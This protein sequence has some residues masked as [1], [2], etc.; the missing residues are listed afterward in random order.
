MRRTLLTCACTILFAIPL[1]G[2]SISFSATSSFSATARSAV[3]GFQCSNLNQPVSAYCMS[4]S[5]GG[6]IFSREYWSGTVTASAGQGAGSFIGSPYLVQALIDVTA[7]CNSPAAC[8]SQYG[9]ADVG[10]DLT[11]HGPQGTTGI[12]EVAYIFAY[13]PY[14]NATYNIGLPLMGGTSN[15]HCIGSAPRQPLHIQLRRTLPHFYRG[16]R[17]MFGVRV[18]TI[19]HAHWCAALLV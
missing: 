11:I 13:V 15:C 14:L 9:T 1:A 16:R 18:S 12:L 8:V 10:V 5:S 6:D 3:G 19:L 7:Y 2:S 17:G 4:G